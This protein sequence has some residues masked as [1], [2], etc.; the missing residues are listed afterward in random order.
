MQCR[1]ND[2]KSITY[3]KHNAEYFNSQIRENIYVF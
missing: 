3:L 1:A 2:R